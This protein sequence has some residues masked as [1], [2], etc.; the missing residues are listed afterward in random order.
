MKNLLRTAFERKAA[1]QLFQRTDIVR[2]SVYLRTIIRKLTWSLVVI[3]NSFT[4]IS[5]LKHFTEIVFLSLTF[6]RK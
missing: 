5:F 6:F 4:D 3:S 1:R 2:K